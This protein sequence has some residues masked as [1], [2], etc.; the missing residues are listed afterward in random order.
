MVYKIILKTKFSVFED[1]LKII[2]NIHHLMIIN[3]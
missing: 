3:K 1:P 2:K